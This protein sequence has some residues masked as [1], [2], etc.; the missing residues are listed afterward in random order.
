MFRQATIV[1]SPLIIMD[2]MNTFGYYGT[3]NT[4]P[5]HFN[6]TDEGSYLVADVYD[7]QVLEFDENGTFLKLLHQKEILMDK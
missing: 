7:E 4:D 3:H 1:S 6:I 5:Y 2:L